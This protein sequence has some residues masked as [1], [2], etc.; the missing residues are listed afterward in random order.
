MQ[1]PIEEKL[2]L[3]NVPVL[4][5]RGE[6]DAVAPLPWV[7]LV[8]ELIPSSTYVVVK[9]ATHAITFSSPGKLARIALPFFG[10][11]RKV[12]M[13]VEVHSTELSMV[14]AET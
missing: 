14:A 4:V 5:V 9:G 8:A 7:K 10:D 12:E 1:D 3:L 13:V 11:K 2:P 6:H